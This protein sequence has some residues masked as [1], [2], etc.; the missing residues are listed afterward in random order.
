MKPLHKFTRRLGAILRPRRADAATAIGQRK[1]AARY[2]HR[3]EPDQQDQRFVID[4]N[5]DEC[6][7]VG[8]PSETQSWDN[9]RFISAASVVDV[10]REKS[11]V[12]RAPSPITC[13]RCAP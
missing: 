12:W 3:T 1:R 8:S 10:L 4:T 13:G 7:R 2:N 11:C 9:P 6:R 5:S